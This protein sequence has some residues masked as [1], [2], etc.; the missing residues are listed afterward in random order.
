MI[1]TIQKTLRKK[2][3]MEFAVSDK[4]QP[5]VAADS[6]GSALKGMQCN[7]GI[8]GIEQTVERSAAG[9]HADGHG[10]LGEAI[11]LHGG[12]DL[13]GEDLFDGLF[14]ALF[15][16]AL[17]GQ[18][19]VKGRTN[20][21]P[22]LVRHSE[23][24]LPTLEREPQIPGWGL[25]RSLEEAMQQHHAFPRHAENH[26]PDVSI[27]QVATYLPQAVAETATIGHAERPTEF[28]L[29]YIPAD[30]LAVLQG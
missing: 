26:P 11:L 27:S 4:F 28:D 18:K 22:F 24:L 7:A 21:A 23:H 16:N 19:V 17:F 12:F 30:Q 14:L 9:L 8:G 2:R 13:I 15:Q 25:L 6:G 29:L 5:E 10:R 3:G 20:R 1:E